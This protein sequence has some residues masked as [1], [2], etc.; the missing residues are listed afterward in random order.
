MKK[1]LLHKAQYEFK[2]IYVWTVSTKD[3]MK[4]YLG[5]GVDGIIVSKVTDLV[6]VLNEEEFQN[7]VRLATRNDNAFKL[8][9]PSIYKIVVKTGDCDGAGTN[10]NVYITLC[11]DRNSCEYLLDT[12][13]H[14]DFER[15]QE[16]EYHLLAADVGNV[17]KVR[18]RHDNSR[19][20][21]SPWFLDWIKVY[22]DNQSWDFP[23]N[24]WLAKDEDDRQIDRTLEVN[25]AAL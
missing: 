3:L 24:K 14:D 21:Y 22:K 18:I 13:D 8:P 6:E 1:A 2:L 16:H 15:G 7:S 20:L 10:A 25:N 4:S 12:P 23:C 9:L 19:G 17:N 5:M 11:G